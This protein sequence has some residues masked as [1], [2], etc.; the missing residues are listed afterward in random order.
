MTYKGDTVKSSG[1][2]R[3]F[4]PG[5]VVFL[6]ISS[7]LLDCFYATGGP[8][9]AKTAS[10]LGVPGPALS[11][12]VAAQR[13][14]ISPDIY[15]INEYGADPA[16]L[17]QL[18][19]PVVRWGGNLATQYN[20]Q[21]DASNHGSDYFFVGGD[22]IT[23]AQPNP[24]S[25]Q[26]NLFIN[27]NNTNGSKS[28]LTI[29][30]IDYVN[31]DGT[32]TCSYKVSRYPGITQQQTEII[33]DGQEC[34]NGRYTDGTPIPNNNVLYNHVANSPTLQQGWIN[35]LVSHYGNA[36]GSG[37]KYYEFDNEPSDWFET[38]QDVHPGMLSYEELRDKTYLYGPAIKTADP[39]AKTL[40]PSDYGW[41][42]YVDSQDLN[43]QATHGGTWFA[44]WYLQQMKAYEDQHG[45]RILDYFDEH[46]YPDSNG[47]CIALCPAG[48]AAT[49]AQRLRATR[50]LWDPT[51]EDESWINAANGFGPIQLIPRFRQW[52]SQDYPGTK[53]AIT[54]YNFGGLESINGALTQADVLGIFGREQLD[55]ATIW[56]PP[57]AS[58][59]GAYAFKMYLNYDGAGGKFGDT[60]VLAS[61]ADQ[62]QLAIYGAQ[63]SS[64]NALTLMLI[65][66][67][68][69]DLTSS[70][71]LSGFS[72]GATAKVYRYSPANLNAIVAQPDQVVNASGFSATYP[73]NSITLVVIPEII[74]AVY[75]AAPIGSGN[76]FRLGAIRPTGTKTASFT[77]SNLGPAASNLHVALS[78]LSGPDA[79]KFAV[80]NAG[81][82]PLD[83]AGGTSHLVNLSCTPAAL[84][85]ITANLTVTYTLRQGQS[86]ST[87]SY[88]LSCV[89][90]YVVTKAS[91]DGTNGTLSYGLAQTSNT[92]GGGIAFELTGNTTVTFGAG[93]QLPL[94]VKAG[95]MVDGGCNGGPQITIDGS[96][97][98]GDGLQLSGNNNIF[99]LR[100]Q[101]FAGRQ[102]VTVGTGNQLRC[103]ITSRN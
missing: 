48:D 85:T 95:V 25:G 18:R 73:A 96:G 70:L 86:N 91:D 11:V 52:V 49:Q 102:L 77:I 45:V 17:S 43:G 84:G 89:G 16:L 76:T 46:Y 10:V 58:Q 74:P 40:G 36:A 103:V 88:T 4:R 93:I 80:T 39:T 24:P 59:P 38:H 2:V 71:S 68:G 42:V 44:E 90:G 99:G 81:N 53:T 22:S 51:Y 55:L 5:L 101:K 7:S 37:V 50:S 65:N 14:A 31:K 12:N 92:I 13:H 6:L 82:F 26:A 67:T 56:D 75:S 1:F 62:G 78:A 34:G 27:T 29:P 33:F 3:F 30:M 72:P 28:L 98:T 60:S 66:K 20:W 41:A 69:S 15:G 97:H 64:D 35:Y 23:T 54:E 47:P 63:R 9:Q 83:M 61:S 21:A 19:S 8:A 79:A 32:I 87:A 94:I 100:I 57:T